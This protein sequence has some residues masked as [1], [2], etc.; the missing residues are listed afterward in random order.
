MKS[1]YFAYGSNM[2]RD[3]MIERGV[4]ILSEKVGFIEGWKLVFNKIA[5]SPSGAGYANITKEENSKVYGVLYKIENSD[6]K[7]LDKYEGCP[8]HYKRE[9]IP[10]ILHDG[11]K[12]TAEVYIAQSNKTREGLKPTE[13][14]MKY[15][16]NGA[17]Q[18]NLPSS[19]I[20][21]LESIEVLK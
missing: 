12:I 13:E 20:K 2:D 5:T 18:H 6:L 9:R 10:V 15:L 7:K 19:Y 4:R 11:K 1:F 17:K 14:Y 8:N 21:F 16:I 3:R